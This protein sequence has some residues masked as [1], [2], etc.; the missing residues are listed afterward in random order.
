MCGM[1]TIEDAQAAALASVCAGLD[2]YWH[3]LEG[4]PSTF[5]VSDWLPSFVQESA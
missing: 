5:G 1:T 4:G 3:T 2:W